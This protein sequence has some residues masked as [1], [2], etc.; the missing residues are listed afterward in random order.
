MSR[1]PLTSPALTAALSAL[2]LLACAEETLKGELRL[3]ADQAIMIQNKGSADWERCR[4]AV[5]ETYVAGDIQ[6]SAGQTKL[7]SLRTL[8][9]RSGA[10]FNVNLLRATNAELT[11]FVGLTNKQLSL[12]QSFGRP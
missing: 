5:N 1:Q 6:L 9:S 12:V 3:V 11:C 10:P 7:V 2:I 4:L 8:V